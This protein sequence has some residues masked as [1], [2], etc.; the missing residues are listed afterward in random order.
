MFLLLCQYV[1]MLH[2]TTCRSFARSI[3]L[4]LW[5]LQGPRLRANGSASQSAR[6]LLN[7]HF[8]C[9]PYM[10][11]LP[12]HLNVFW[13][14]VGTYSIHGAYGFEIDWTF[15]NP[16]FHWW[17]SMILPMAMNWGMTW[18][19][20]SSIEVMLMPNTSW[21]WIW[22]KTL[23]L[24]ETTI[25]IDTTSTKP[26]Q[27]WDAMVQAWFVP[28]LDDYHVVDSKQD[29]T[30]NLTISVWSLVFTVLFHWFSKPWPWPSTCWVQILLGRHGF[31]TCPNVTPGPLYESDCVGVTLEV[32]LCAKLCGA[33]LANG[34]VTPWAQK[35]S[36]T[37]Q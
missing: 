21:L 23:P 34:F 9:A 6:C 7:D 14:N 18:G 27:Y 5:R 28:N 2:T 17:S 26:E 25:R 19:I 16:K 30:T 11:Y 3:C 29:Y 4:G 10:V 36:A 13:A 12:I 35:R 8:P 20:T 37:I 24:N 31:L 33:K 15:M 32:L 1:P 22:A